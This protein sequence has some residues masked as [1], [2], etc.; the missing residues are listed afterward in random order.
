MT[1]HRSRVAERLKLQGE[2]GVGRLSLREGLA[3]L[4]ALGV[5]R[6]HRGRGALVQEG[7]DRH[8][9]I[10]AAIGDADPDRARQAARRILAS[11]DDCKIGARIDELGERIALAPAEAAA[12]T[13]VVLGQ[14]YAR[15]RR[16]RK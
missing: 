7:I 16:R 13:L 3:R 15:K 8:R 9:P 4:S 11:L 1:C 6:A 5:I 10:L 12:A 2:M 14:V